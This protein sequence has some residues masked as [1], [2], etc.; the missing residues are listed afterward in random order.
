MMMVAEKLGYAVLVQHVYNSFN[1]RNADAALE[2]IHP[3]A[4]WAN[5]MEGGLLTGHEEIN[6]YWHR[7]WSYIDWH[8]K[9]GDITVEDSGNVVVNTNQIIRDLSG[10]IVSIRDVQ[11]V[12]RI[13]DGLITEMRIR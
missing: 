8:V 4:E 11:H 9:F 13:E 12:F 6:A 7:Q 10:N 2:V 5:A 1:L 3:D